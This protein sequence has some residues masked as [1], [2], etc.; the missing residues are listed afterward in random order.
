MVILNQKNF[1]KNHAPMFQIYEI[2]RLPF[3]ITASYVDV[4]DVFF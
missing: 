1:F 4:F 2:F 3:S